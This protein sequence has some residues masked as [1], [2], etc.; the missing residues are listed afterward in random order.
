[1][2][3]LISVVPVKQRRNRNAQEEANFNISSYCYRVRAHVDGNLQ[4]I[5]VC[6]KA[7]LSLHG[8]GNNRVQ[9]IKKHLTSFGEIKPDG[10]GKHAN[11]SNALSVETKAKVISFIQSLK[12]RK[13]HYSLKDTSKF[14]LPE[15]LNKS[16]LHRMYNETNKDN[17]VGFTTFRDIFDN[18]FNISF[19]YPRKDTCSTCDVLKAEIS[20]LEKKSMERMTKKLKIHYYKI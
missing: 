6:Y 12:G 1:M 18:N 14:Y 10:R 13:S 2:G 15:E 7:F 17:T 8:I 9:T 4:D 11:R 3:G 20:V 5:T 16:K 19:G